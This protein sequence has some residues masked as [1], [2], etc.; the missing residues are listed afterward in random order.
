MNRAFSPPILRSPVTQAVGLGWDDSRRWRLS[1]L[2]VFAA[3]AVEDCE[4][5]DGAAGYEAG[6]H[7][8]DER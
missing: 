2:L 8:E 5:C 1:E 3:E 7:A 6:G 4:A